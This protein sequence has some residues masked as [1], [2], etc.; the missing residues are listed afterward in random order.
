MLQSGDVLVSVSASLKPIT[1]AHD[2]LFSEIPKGGRRQA[3]Q[4]KPMNNHSFNCSFLQIL[5]F[6]VWVRMDIVPRYVA[7]GIDAVR[8]W[9]KVCQSWTLFA[10]LQLDG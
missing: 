4:N 1:A 10:M 7:S 5:L 2:L 6:L 8:R 3:N 9:E